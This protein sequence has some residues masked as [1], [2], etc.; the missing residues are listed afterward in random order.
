MEFSLANLQ[1]KER[2]SFALRALYEAAGCRK[3]HMGRFEE[4][5]L[6]QEN[7]SFL[8]SEQVITFTD[9]D[10]RLLALKPDVTLSIAKTAQPAPGETLRYYYHENVYR[11]SAESHTFKEISQMGL[12]MLGAVGEAQVQ[13]AVCLAAR[14]L[15]A[16]GAEW[17]LEVSHM[18]YLFGLFDALGVPDAARAKLLEKLREKNAHELRAAAGAAGL[19]DA[20]ADI[21]CSVLSL[22]GSYADTL[23]KAAAL[24]RNDAMRAAVAELEALAVPLEK[25]GG[26]I[27]LDM[28][29]AGEMEYYNGLVFQGYLKTL[30][31]PLLKG[32]RYDLLMQKF[33]PGAGAIGFA[34][35]LDEL[36]RL[37]APL[38]PVQKN[39]TDR[40]MLNV[41]LPKGRLGDKVYNLLA[42]IGYGCPEDY[43]TTRK[44]VV[45]N[46][47]AGIRYFLVKPS[48]VAIY[49]EHGAAD[50]GIVGKD[51]LTEASADVYELLDTGLGKC[52]MCVA[53]PADYKDDPSRPVRVATKFVS[54]AKSYYASM[55]RDI[56]I[57][58]LNGSIEL[59]PI[60]GL[61]DVIVD[62]VETGTT[63][64]ENGL[65]VV[66]EFMPI[67]ARFI[68]NK[69]S[70][71][72]KHAEMDTM[73]E[74]LRAELQNKEEAK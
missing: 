57:I 56:D 32:G 34:V 1:P 4:Y 69:A 33:T 27:R 2:A 8:S 68:A 74:K 37:S 24:C 63:L 31:R 38:P 12:E 49:V 58:K 54:I 36:D 13:Q 59:A 64:R 16:L 35:Y 47:E 71:Q 48:D 65:K 9:L 18:G 67:S 44:L 45:E 19:A 3:Y 17:V 46:P 15:D 11:P 66:T 53:A 43:N 14:S 21:L 22:C 52:R 10:G 6:Y 72:F 25:A 5:G 55:G 39:S 70:Y 7:R 42:V 30:P 61:S 40:V 62:I 26:V 73:L 20:A 28:T 29:L 60:L 50:V 23:A 41:A 51:I